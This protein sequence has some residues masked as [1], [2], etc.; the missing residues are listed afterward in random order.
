MR[1]SEPASCPRAK[2]L[3]IGA[4]VKGSDVFLILLEVRVDAQSHE[5]RLF[6][7]PALALTPT[8]RLTCSR[9]RSTAPEATSRMLTLVPQTQKR[10][11][12]VWS[13]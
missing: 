11:C 7:T 4:E 9:L 3:V 6:S 13:S 1:G 8:P 10:C 5:N 2:Y 12:P